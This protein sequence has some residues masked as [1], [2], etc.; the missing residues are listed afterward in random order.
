MDFDQKLILE[1]NEK[2]KKISD[3]TP[4]YARGETESPLGEGDPPSEFGAIYSD[5]ESASRFLSW[6]SWES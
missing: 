5:S 6:E 3:L 4:R 2:I 1:K